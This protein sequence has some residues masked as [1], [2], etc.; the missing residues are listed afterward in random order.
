MGQ[1]KFSEIARQL[2]ETGEYVGEITSFTKAGEAR[3]LE[4]SAFT[5]RNGVGEPIGYIGI[6]R[7]VTTR[8]QAEEALRRSEVELTDLFETA[9]IGLHWIDPNGIILRV[10]QAE[11]D[12]LGYSREEYVGRNIVEFHAD[13]EVIDDILQ[14]LRDGEV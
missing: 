5:M 1:E 13:R 14:R 8:N 12:L 11:L 4:L 9:S 6:T 7:D 3:K 2:A 10:N